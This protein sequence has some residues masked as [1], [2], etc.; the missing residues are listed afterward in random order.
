[1]V[2]EW[3]IVII[4]LVIS[5]VFFTITFTFPQLPGD[6]GGGAL[7][8]RTLSVITGAAAIFLV[9]RLIRRPSSDTT[10]TPLES[11][12]KFCGLWRKGTVDEPSVAAR[13]M[14]YVFIFS[15]AYPWFIVKMGFLLSTGVYVFILM[16]LF[17]TKTI[18]SVILSSITAFVLYFFF[19][20]V[21]E[22]YVPPGVWLEGILK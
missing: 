1:M 17:R 20:K 22:A 8:P 5:V 13:R 19:I 16:K 21:L 2:A 14:T 3:I 6:P 18:T 4:A 11:L 15:I 9:V 12:R 10:N 7:F